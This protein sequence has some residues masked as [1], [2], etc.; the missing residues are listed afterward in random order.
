MHGKRNTR[1][2]YVSE[3]NLTVKN[4]SAATFDTQYMSIRICRKFSLW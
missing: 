2:F 1:F 4:Y 3:K